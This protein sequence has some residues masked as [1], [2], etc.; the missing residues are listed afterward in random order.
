MEYYLSLSTKCCW[1]ASKIAYSIGNMRLQRIQLRLVKGLWIPFHN[2][3]YESGSK[4]LIRGRVVRW[5]DMYFSKQCDIMPPT[6]RLYLS[7]NIPCRE[8][9][10]A[11]KDDMLLE[12]LLDVQYQH[13]NQSWRLQFNNVVIPR[14]VRMI[15]C[16][17]CPS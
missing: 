4:V 9:Y 16:S 13:F 3:Y 12:C 10:Q 1:V 7:N 6:W 5:M 15:V 17:I 11:Y 14:K 8:V 2:K